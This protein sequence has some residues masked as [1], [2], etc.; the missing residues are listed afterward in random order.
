MARTNSLAVPLTG[1]QGLSRSRTRHF[2]AFL[3]RLIWAL[4]DSTESYDVMEP[5]GIDPRW[6]VFGDLHAYFLTAFPKVS[7]FSL[8]LIENVPHDAYHL[9]MSS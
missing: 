3:R 8:Y 6:A 1:W 7:V 5:V 9:A 2:Y 4:D